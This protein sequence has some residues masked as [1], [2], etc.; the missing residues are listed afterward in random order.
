MAGMDAPRR[1]GLDISPTRTWLRQRIDGRVALAVGLAWL[2]LLQ[3][4]T[5]LEP[6]TNQP[7][8]VYG[9]ALE[10]VAWLLLAAM[11]TGLI[12]QRR[13]GLVASL[14]AAGFLTA[15][16]VACPVSGHHPFGAWWFGQ[17]AC[18]L[19]LGAIT[20]AALR[21]TTEPAAGSEGEHRLDP[22]AERQEPVAS[23]ERG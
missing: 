21:R 6:T 4:A 9:I 17:M 8:P 5:A 3:V 15:L 23:A 2:V 7:E 22:V 20:L 1:D 16:S 18:V 19:A 14:G 12:M 10:L 11:A 13:A